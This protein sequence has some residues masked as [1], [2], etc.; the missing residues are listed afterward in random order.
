MYYKPL[1]RRGALIVRSMRDVFGKINLVTSMRHCP[2]FQFIPVEDRAFA[3]QEVSD[4][5]HTL[6]I[7]DLRL[8]PGRHWQDVHANLPRP[9]RFS[10][11]TCAVTK[12]LLPDVSLAGLNYL[13]G[14]R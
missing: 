5:F 1:T 10:R 11:S 2:V 3:F 8:C 7:V 13:Y 12:P 14:L 4:S 9:D 6:V